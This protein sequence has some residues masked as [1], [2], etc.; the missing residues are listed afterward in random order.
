VN[1]HLSAD[2]V[3]LLG[4]KR[5]IKREHN[6]GKCNQEK[7]GKEQVEQRGKSDKEDSL[8]MNIRG[9]IFATIAS[10][11]GDVHSPG[12]GLTEPMT[13]NF[14]S[15]SPSRMNQSTAVNPIMGC[16]AHLNSVQMSNAIPLNSFLMNQV[17]PVNPNSN[18][19]LQH[20]PPN[21]EAMA[22]PQLSHNGLSN[23][24]D[25][26]N[27]TFAAQQAKQSLFQAYQQSQLDLLRKDLSNPNHISEELSHCLQGTESTNQVA[28]PVS[29]AT[30]PDDTFR[31]APSK[32]LTP[33]FVTNP[34]LPV[35][36]CSNEQQ[37]IPL[38]TS[39]DELFD[40]G[41]DCSLL[42]DEEELNVADDCSTLSAELGLVG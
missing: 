31:L 4:L 26:K 19:F 30:H 20:M 11:K 37:G 42:C 38:P 36:K 23:S 21:M 15:G 18:P 41:S 5:R 3:S 40:E 10:A 14:V 28:M 2:P 1:K 13:C 24:F 9:N 29:V 22:T 32:Q 6:T 8:Y 39:I 25:I 12:S 33:A 35:A 34:I 27:A 7:G 16:T 17:I